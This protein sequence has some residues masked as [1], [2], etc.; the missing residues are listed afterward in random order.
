MRRKLFIIY[1]Q[2]YPAGAI[3][4]LSA[5]AISRLAATGMQYS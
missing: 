5:D 2:T 4:S 1:W 3:T